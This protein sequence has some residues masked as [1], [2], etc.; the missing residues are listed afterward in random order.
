M[1]KIIV[2]GL[3]PEFNELITAIRG[4]AKAPMLEELENTLANQEAL[5]KQLPKDSVNDEEALFRKKNDVGARS[6]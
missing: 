1:K 4:W 2:H 6:L 3:R 5:D